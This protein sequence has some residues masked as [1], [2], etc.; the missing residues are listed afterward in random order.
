MQAVDHDLIIRDR[1]GDVDDPLALTRPNDGTFGRYRTVE[2]EHPPIRIARQTL[3]HLS[4][5]DGEN[6]S[7]A[8]VI[9]EV[10]LPDDL[11]GGLVVAQVWPAEAS[12]GHIRP[13]EDLEALRDAPSLV[14]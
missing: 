7:L 8:A 2:V 4:L 5:N 11:I 9:P 1:D 10:E 6:D 3:L 14:L 13:Q 12:A